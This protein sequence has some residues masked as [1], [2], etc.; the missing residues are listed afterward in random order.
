MAILSF[1]HNF[2]WILF[3]IVIVS[4]SLGFKLCM[5]ENLLGN[6]YFFFEDDW[7]YYMEIARNF[8]AG[9]YF[10]FDRITRTNGVHYLWEFILVF[11]YGL[12]KVI[13]MEDF[14][15]RGTLFLNAVIYLICGS[16]FF[17]PLSTI[18]GHFAAMAIIVSGMLLYST[19][20]LNGMET[21]VALLAFLVTTIYLQ[22]CLR[23]DTLNIDWLV[24]AVLCFII[25]LARVDAI[26]ISLSLYAG[27][28]WRFRDLP[29]LKSLSCFVIMIGM[30]AFINFIFF[31]SSFPIS[32]SVKAFWAEQF[33]K[34]VVGIWQYGLGVIARSFLGSIGSVYRVESVSIGYVV[35]LSLLV[36]VFFFLFYSFRSRSVFLNHE[37][38]VLIVA[39][40]SGFTYLVSQ[41]IY[42]SIFS[43]KIWR[44]YLGTGIITIYILASVLVFLII[45]KYADDRFSSILSKLVASVL[46]I[47]SGYI[48]YSTTAIALNEIRTSDTYGKT[49]NRVVRWIT[50]NTEADDIIGIWA[51]GQIG[52][53]SDRHVINLEGLVG[54]VELLNANKENRLIEYIATKN[55]AYVIQWFPHKA[56]DDRNQYPKKNNSGFVGLRLRLIYPNRDRFKFIGTIAMKDRLRDHSVYIYRLLP[57]DLHDR[58]G[59]REFR[60]L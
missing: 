42:Y 19:L 15:V 37:K 41:L 22:R 46:L 35:V 16:I 59:S 51:A 60:R 26:V 53:Y 10:S 8:H 5:E 27:M 9:Q 4:I 13:E 24:F 47:A 11:V 12:L 31:E 43:P 34:P 30:Y 54:D 32:G 45:R 58:F 56:M 3:I 38:Y 20:F 49:A 44:W 6:N 18:V 21:S 48:D 39:A 14:F 25:F 40:F 50:D 52:Y 29:L 2:I 57:E 36:P 1:R 23:H 7:F 55:V 33:P 28:L 17:R